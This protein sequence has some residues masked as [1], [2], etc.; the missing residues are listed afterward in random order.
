DTRRKRSVGDLRRDDDSER[1]RLGIPDCL[2]I[3]ADDRIPLLQDRFRVM[4]EKLRAQELQAVDPPRVSGLHRRTELGGCAPDALTVTL[5]PQ[6]G[7]APEPETC[8]LERLPAL[9]QAAAG[10]ETLQARDRT[11]DALRARSED[12]ARLR[13]RRTRDRPRQLAQQ[14]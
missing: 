10:I 13:Q 1:D 2:T 8:D 4:T 14:R 5:D 9:G 12:A 3:V 7:C 6:L 11:I